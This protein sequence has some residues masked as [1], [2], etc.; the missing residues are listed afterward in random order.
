[1]RGCLTLPARLPSHDLVNDEVHDK[2]VK[3]DAFER[4]GV[5]RKANAVVAFESSSVFFLPAR[6]AAP[7][8]VPLAPR[9]RASSVG[10]LALDLDAN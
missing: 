4:F 8:A 10:L 2:I 7:F 9:R 6:S 1:M 3:V 5:D